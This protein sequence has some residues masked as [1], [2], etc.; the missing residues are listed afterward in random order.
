MFG[1][2]GRYCA[3]GAVAPVIYLIAWDRCTGFAAGW[4]GAFF[5]M[6]GGVITWMVSGSTSPTFCAQ[7]AAVV[8]ETS[9]RAPCARKLEAST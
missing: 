9:L 8:C 6:I 2:E 7:Q 1:H 3:A 4:C 5:G